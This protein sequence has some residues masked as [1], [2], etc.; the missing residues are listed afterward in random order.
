MQKTFF[1]IIKS[2]YP[3][4]L[5]YTFQYFMVVFFD[6]YRTWPPF[7][8]PMHFL[9]GVT[10][11]ITGYFLLQIAREEKWLKIESKLVFLFVVVCF[12]SLMATLWEFYEFVMD[13]YFHTVNQPS[14]ADTM[15]DMFLGLSGGLVAGMMEVS[16]FF[17]KGKIF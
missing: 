16:R 14:I 7:D 4:F 11:G 17:R 12:V 6:L 10:M 5:L 3:P 2:F 9:G 8:I 1:K 15:G 13:Y